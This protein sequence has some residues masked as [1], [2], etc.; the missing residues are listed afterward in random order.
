MQRKRILLVEP[1]YSNKYPPLGLMKI[2]TS[3]KLSGDEVH[4]CKGKSVSTRNENWDL[5]YITTLFTFQWNKTVDTIRFWS[6]GNAQVLVGG[7]LA[8]LMP[9]EIERETGVCPHVGPYK[10][11]IPLLQSLV[12]NDGELKQLSSC[13]ESFGIDCLPPDYGVFDKTEVP[14]KDALENCYILRTSKGCRRNCDFCAV[15]TLEPDFIERLPLEPS[16]SYIRKRDGE[17]QNLLL[18][19]DNVLLSPSFDAIIDEIAAVGFAKGSKLNRKRR[20]VDFNQGLDVRLLTKKQLKKLATIELRPLR[21]A[22]D[23]I[24][25]KDV[26]KKKV[27]WALELGFKEISSYVLYNHDDTPSNLYHRLEI[28]CEL[29]EKH[30]GR[31]YSFPMKYIPCGDKDRKHVGDNWTRRQIRGVQCILNATHGIAPTNPEF[32][33]LA[34]GKNVTEFLQLIQMPEKYIIHRQ[35]HMA[36]SDISC[37][38]TA[39]KSMSSSEKRTARRIISVGKRNFDCKHNNREIAA[40]LSHY[41]KEQA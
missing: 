38:Q 20:F 35:R 27:E 29:N 13:I 18:L 33:R 6:K 25:L 19:D 34:F 8:S 22:F 31:I 23:N 36:N 4:F 1:S 2:A 28:G 39:Y 16:I 5:I 3:H 21:L 9:N 32:L 41:K 40:F 7:V 15:G 37:W 14:Y 26:Y 11:N 30:A 24:S 12:E 10:G 17:K